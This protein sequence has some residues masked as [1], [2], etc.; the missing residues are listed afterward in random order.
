MPPSPL[1]HVSS[2]SL[3]LSRS[4]LAGSLGTA[5]ARWLPHALALVL[6]AYW[7]LV[8][9]A[10]FDRLE[11]TS[12]LFTNLEL[13][14]SFFD[15]RPLLW[16]NAYG[17]HKAFH[18]YYVAL[19]LY[20]LTRFFGA[21]GLFIAQAALYYW[22]VHKILRRASSAAEH[23]RELYWVILVVIALGPI[24]FWIWDNPIYGFHYELLLVPLSLLFAVSLL[25][26]SR[27]AW[28]FAALIVFT[29]EEGAILAWCIHVLYEVLNA[30]PGVGGSGELSRLIRRL[31]WITGAWILVFIAGLTLLIAMGAKAGRL[32]LAMSGLRG[33]V[34]NSGTSSLLIAS[35][36]DAVLLLAAGGLVYLAGIPLRGL[37][38]TALISV[39]LFVASAIGA[40]I[41][42]PALRAHGLAWPPRFAML[43]GV[44]LASSMFAI[45][46]ARTPIF[47]ARRVRRIALATAVV[48]AIVA[49][50][51]A[52]EARRD[53][54]FLH[55]FTLQAFSSTPRYV[56]SALTRVEDAFLIC[57]GRELPT[58]TPV[59]STGGLF[60]RF[61]RQDLL[62]PDR[63][64]T[65]WRFPELVVCDE[66]GRIPFEYGCLSLARSLPSS[67]YEML[68]L[69]HLSVR[70]ASSAKPVVEAC[71]ARA[72]PGDTSA[73]PHQPEHGRVQPP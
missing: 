66:S 30:E 54:R 26:R 22:A 10:L 48:A 64:H 18:S 73:E 5:G 63:V 1:L 8:K 71:A 42:G 72:S 57:L 13:T 20:P 41:Y 6:I 65:A 27:L 70:Y 24:A 43:W 35:L 16:E 21:Y 60:G 34:D 7:F 9:A 4:V 55:R 14:R 50:I 3:R 37:A 47:A 67:S 52:L 32:G 46:R 33:L 56:A 11:Y 51:V 62:W 36:V 58:H 69:H 12:D 25:E 61:H 40:L 53:Y 2:R 17:N 45:E 59:T 38:A 15:G 23:R 68:H 19:L 49:Q 29:R 39:P 28:L 44:V 31:A